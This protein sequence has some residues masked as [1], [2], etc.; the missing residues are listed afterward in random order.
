M[1]LCFK[2]CIL[3]RDDGLPGAKHVA[4]IDDCIISL[5]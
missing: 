2:S 4:L 5:L 1:Y 3:V